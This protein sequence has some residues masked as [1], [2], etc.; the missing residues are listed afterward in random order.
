MIQSFDIEK[1]VLVF[2][3]SGFIGKH[4]IKNLEKEGY[5]IW[6]FDLNKSIHLQRNY[7]VGDVL[8]YDSVLTSLEE[9]KPDIVINLAA[10]T[11]MDGTK[12]YD[13]KV[14]FLGLSN[15]VRALG[16]LQLESVRLLHVSTQF[17]TSPGYEPVGDSDLDPYTVYGEAKAVAELILRASSI[18]NWLILRPSGV[19]GSHHPTFDNGLWKVMKHRLFIQPELATKRSYIHVDTLSSQ[20]IRFLQT[21]WQ[22]IN[23]GTY[24]LGNTPSDPR[25]LMDAFSIAV[26]GRRCRRMNPRVFFYLF[27]FIRILSKLGIKLPLDQQRYD[28]LTKDYLIDTEKTF[29]VIGE[30]PEDLPY[31]IS[32]TFD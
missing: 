32:K 28:V 19:W 13:Y 17:V 24:Y 29:A 31:A 4:L 27:Q 7:F 26:S 2:G 12:L 21:D 25:T 8:D 1:K 23:K 22:K 14:N 9:V 6:N 11:R 20:L 30:V 3:G 10:E 18:P 16:Q 15:L 5:L